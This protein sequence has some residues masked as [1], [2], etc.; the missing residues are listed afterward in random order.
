MNNFYDAFDELG[1]TTSA[2]V[3][4]FSKVKDKKD[5]EVLAWLNQVKDALLEQGHNR[6]SQQRQNMFHYRG[7]SHRRWEREIGADRNP[8]LHK[9]K[10]VVV[11][12]LFDLVETKVSQMNRLKP[13][14]EVLPTNEEWED[15]SAAK[16][17]D[18][19]IKH[20]WYVNNIDYISQRMH[21]HARIFGESYLFVDWDSSKGDLHPAYVAA[22]DMGLKEVELP[23]GSLHDMK[24]TVKTG[25]VSYEIEVPWRVLLQRKPELDKV[26]YCFRIKLIPTDKLKAQYPEKKESIQVTDDLKTFDMEELN[27]RFVEEH[28]IVFEFW[29]K[30]TED[31]PEG[32]Y[33]KFVKD[34]ILEKGPHKFTHKKLPFIRLTDLDAPDILNG[35]S[36]FEM[37]MPLQNMLNNG[38]TL[39]AK[40]IWLMA[41]AKWMMPR[42]AAKIEQLGNDNTIVQYQGPIAP[43]MI[44]TAPNPP[45]VYAWVDSLKQ[46]MQ[47][48]Y[49][50]HGISRG[51]VPKGITAASALQFL[52]ELENERA[53]TDI[54]KHGFMI[55]E[56]AQMSIAVAADKYDIEDGRMV[57]IVGENNKY[58][59]RHFDVANLNKNYDIRY[60]LSTGLPETKSARYQR[61]LDAMQRN[62]QMLQPERWEELLELANERKMQTLVS[63]AIKAADSENED[64][65]QG[66]PVAPPEEWED[67]IQHWDSHARAMQSRSFKEEA[68]PEI[69][70][71]FK[72]HVLITEKAM[73]EKARSNPLFQSKLATLVNFPLFYHADSFAPASKEHQEAM[74]QG[75]ANRGDAVSGMIPGTPMEEQQANINQG[76][77]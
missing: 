25:D 1:A 9:I 3:S 17:T 20:L 22:R 67:H 62:P 35:V 65:M 47:T 50:S 43:Q 53:T 51:E 36:K 38:E 14:V 56:M 58:L 6:T 49:G 70:A 45:E 28:T 12:H 29:H 68:T 24:K 44:Q 39:I 7:V 31:C 59:I 66:E 37:I 77:G 55:R 74:V 63:E 72:E 27:D 26:E 2:E 52:N 71:A 11:N 34:G 13:A 41:H 48:I 4:A 5:E 18:L 23:D 40:N 57:R 42:G 30:E 73:L 10:R 54:A 16:V 69:R 32:R 46:K 64:L 75:Q 60:D 19:L 61:I 76:Q 33:I 21:R 15:K 8:R